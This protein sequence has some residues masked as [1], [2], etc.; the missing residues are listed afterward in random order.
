MHCRLSLTLAAVTVLLVAPLAVPRLASVAPSGQDNLGGPWYSTWSVPAFVTEV[1]SPKAEFPNSISRDGLSLYFQRA[2]AAGDENLYVAHRA[3]LESPWAVPV[4]LPDGVNSGAN[5]RG[6]FVSADGHWLFFSSSRTGGLGDNDLYLSWRRHVHDD[7]A[8]ELPVNILEL[9]TPGFDSGPALTE[10]ESG[11]R[12]LYFVSNPSG[13]QA[14]ADIYVSTLN[15]DGTFGPAVAVTELNSPLSEGCPRLR[16]DGREIFF[17]SNRDGNGMDIFV[18]RR[19][20]RDD[21]WSPPESVSEL[22]TPLNDTTPILAWNAREMFIGAFRPDA[23]GIW[24]TYRERRR[25]R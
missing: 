13:T 9:N 10:D 19:A 21:P 22:N 12:Q 14:F 1:N 20:S 17:Q 24:V 6:A 4:K 18:S 16:K 11:R 3:D 5:D 25:G 23:G 8:W 2:D 7:A 15:D